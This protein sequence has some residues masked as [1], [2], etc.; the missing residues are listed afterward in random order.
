MKNLFY[1]HL[2]KK[3]IFILL[4]ALVFMFSDILYKVF[5]LGYLKK[6]EK[7][8][9]FLC[10]WFDFTYQIGI[11][12]AILG[13][14][15]YKKESDVINKDLKDDKN[16]KNK[17]FAH[18]NFSKK[19]YTN[20]L[21]KDIKYSKRKKFFI[22]F[23]I[24]VLIFTKFS[25]EY[26]KNFTNPSNF[27]IFCYDGSFFSDLFFLFMFIESYFLHKYFSLENY[28]FYNFKYLA[29]SII[30]VC[31]LMKMIVVFILSKNNFLT[32]FNDLGYY[33]FALII[34]FLHSL[35]FNLIHIY[36]KV[37]LMD[38]HK[39]FALN[40]LIGIVY[41]IYYILTEY[42]ND[43]SDLFS[44]PF[45]YLMLLN[46]IYQT[47]NVILQTFILTNFQI[48]YFG[49]VFILFKLFNSIQEVQ[50][51]FEGKDLS[52]T[53]N[54]ILVFIYIFSYVLG[55]IAFLIFSEILQLNFFGLNENTKN[56]IIE[57]EIDEFNDSIGSGI[58]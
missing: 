15:L 45:I 2:E 30:G 49:F 39:L 5:F 53:K 48:L 43:L 40:G 50:N 17:N 8:E 31:C 12:S 56:N 14:F 10:T 34:N 22:F 57:R 20:F 7:N 51:F 29:L 41:Y 26:I 32:D 4:N 6:K 16:I 42:K 28:V 58:N 13:T 37:F 24:L 18:D 36:I 9:N 46:S 1:L 27:K 3:L 47:F 33:S 35:L 55:L 11:F 25:E 19:S 23:F 38:G 44:N 54:S 52:T 21:N